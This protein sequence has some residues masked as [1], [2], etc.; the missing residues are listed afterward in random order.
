MLQRLIKRTHQIIEAKDQCETVEKY[1]ILST[2][3]FLK[4]EEIV[5]ISQT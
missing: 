1:S 5:L 3:S 2:V 4:E